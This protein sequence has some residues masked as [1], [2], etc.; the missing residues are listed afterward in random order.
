MCIH[1][2]NSRLPRSIRLHEMRSLC[3]LCSPKI[4][5]SSG[6][7]VHIS[8][9]ISSPAISPGTATVPS[10][11]LITSPSSSSSS[12][13]SVAFRSIRIVSIRSFSPTLQLVDTIS[14]RPVAILPFAPF[15]RLLAQVSRATRATSS[16]RSFVWCLG[17]GVRSKLPAILFAGCCCCWSSAQCQRSHASVQL[18]VLRR[19]AT[20]RSFSRC[21]PAN[22]MCMCFVPVHCGCM[23]D[24]DCPRAL[25]VCECIFVHMC[26]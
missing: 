9:L 12:S 6:N 14:V 23:D 10:K 20:V 26:A 11:M 7:G 22:R 3:A 4:Y 2:K 19:P 18:D 24:S 15:A 16:H 5:C 17:N 21:R 25:C 13:P 1:T 8:A